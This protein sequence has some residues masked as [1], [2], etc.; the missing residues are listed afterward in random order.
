MTN[1]AA[2]PGGPRSRRPR[3]LLTPRSCLWSRLPTGPPRVPRPFPCPPPPPGQ[4]RAVSPPR[5]GGGPRTAA[6]PARGAATPRSALVSPGPRN[7]PSGSR[8]RR[9]CASRGSRWTAGRTRREGGGRGA[10][11][12]VGR[13]RADSTGAAL[14]GQH[15]LLPRFLSA[16]S[17]VGPAPRVPRKQR[18]GLERASRGASGERDPP[19]GLS[20][21]PLSP[22]L[23]WAGPWSCWA[24]AS[25]AWPPAT[26]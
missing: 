20:A 1:M 26:T 13:S 12:L 23:R 19:A 16:P 6:G 18:P 8:K 3:L 10:P 9:A 21:S 22:R 14:I 11:A 25:A 7:R 4:R 2:L 15:R 5:A 17:W 24:E